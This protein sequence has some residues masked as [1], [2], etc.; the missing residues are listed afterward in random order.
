MGNHSS[1][2]YKLTLLRYAYLN[3]DDRNKTQCLSSAKYIVQF[4][5]C[6][7]LFVYSHFTNSKLYSQKP[8]RQYSHFTNTAVSSYAD[9]AILSKGV[10]AIYGSWG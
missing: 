1:F 10:S 7:I 8:Y 4:F 9:E 3:K 6:I 5:K 2:Y